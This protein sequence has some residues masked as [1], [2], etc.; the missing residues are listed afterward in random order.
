MVTV[1]VVL[2]CPAETVT[3]VGTVALVPVAD[4]ETLR[5]LEGA[6]AFK[7]TVAVDGDPPV[8]LAGDKVTVAGTGARIERIA[9]AVLAP[10]AA[11][12]VADVFV[13][14]AEVET[15]NVVLACP[16]GTVTKADVVAAGL[17]DPSVRFNP[18]LGAGP[19]S[20]TVA[21]E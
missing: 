20:T 16:P 18:P 14:T 4:S 11:E 13:A 6:M 9:D 12:M 8:T 3:I 5:P 10:S 7:V 15:I 2:D 1:K 21:V 19:F 17:L